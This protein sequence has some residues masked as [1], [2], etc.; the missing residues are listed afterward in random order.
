MYVE[1]CLRGNE[2]SASFNN[3]AARC[4]KPDIMGL[5]QGG[6]HEGG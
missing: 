5:E 3:E 2:E 6:G 4:R 1:L